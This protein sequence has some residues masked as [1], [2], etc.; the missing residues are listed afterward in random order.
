MW[1][2]RWR[3]GQWRRRRWRRGTHRDLG[4]CLAWVEPRDRKRCQWRSGRKLRRGIPGRGWWS[5]QNSGPGRC[6]P[7]RHDHPSSLHELTNASRSHHSRQGLPMEPLPMVAPY[8][9]P[10]AFRLPHSHSIQPNVCWRAKVDCA[11]AGT[12]VTVHGLHQREPPC[13]CLP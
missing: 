13:P 6:S 8:R 5:W 1:R 2:R 12:H 9:T 11:T 10:S 4:R 3:H 7:H